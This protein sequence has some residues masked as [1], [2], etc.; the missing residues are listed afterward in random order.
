[1]DFLDF[2]S[3]TVQLNLDWQKKF[4]KAKVE[5]DFFFIFIS[6]YAEMNFLGTKM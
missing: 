3:F 4:Y 6:S 5:K 2:L 1:M